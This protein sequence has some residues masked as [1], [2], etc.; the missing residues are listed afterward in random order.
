MKPT[1]LELTLDLTHPSL[2]GSEDRS[3]A[4]VLRLI[5]DRIEAEGICPGGVWGGVVDGNGSGRVGY[6]V[7]RAGG[8]S[9]EQ[10]LRDFIKGDCD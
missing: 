8:G 7:V 5:A 9:E 2:T 3:V 6:W 4:R 10:D 1:S